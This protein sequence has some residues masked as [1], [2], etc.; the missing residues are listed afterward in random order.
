MEPPPRAPSLS[1][2][3]LS[4]LGTSLAKAASE[5]DELV[6]GPVPA[7]QIYWAD[8][9]GIHRAN[10]DGPDIHDLI[11]ALDNGMPCF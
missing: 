9:Q 8:N 6:Q 11:K 5:P 4:G 3:S 1:M 7:V 2:R 10:L